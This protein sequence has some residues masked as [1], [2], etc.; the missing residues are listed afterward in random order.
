MADPKE[1]E[2]P[3]PKWPNQHIKYH[4]Q[5]EKKK[6]FGLRE[7]GSGRLSDKSTVNRGPVVKQ[8]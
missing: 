6:H 7:P 5:Q 3:F 4:L 2:M 1:A 8:T